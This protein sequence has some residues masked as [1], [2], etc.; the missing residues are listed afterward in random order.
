MSLPGGMLDL[1]EVRSA[2]PTYEYECRQCG[3]LFEHFQSISASHLKKCPACGKLKLKRLLGSGAGI[4]FKG[5]GFYQTDYRKAAAPEKAAAPA[6]AAKKTEKPADKPAAGAA[7]PG[8][9]NE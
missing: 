7:K 9:V 5:T 3:H 1:F 8:A 4:I 2:M 6:P